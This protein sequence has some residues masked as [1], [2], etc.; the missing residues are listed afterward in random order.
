MFRRFFTKINGWIMGGYGKDNLFN[1]LIGLFGVVFLCFVALACLTDS[2]LLR[3]ILIF[4]PFLIL[5]FAVYRMLSKDTAKRANENRIFL[6]YKDKFFAFFK[7]L[8]NK[9][10]YRKTH[11]FKKCP[12]CK[13][14]LKLARIKGEHTVRCPACGQSFKFKI[15]TGKKKVEPRPV[16]K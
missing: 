4:A 15:R 1:F 14:N 5:I 6:Y 13:S 11:I 8:K 7:L 16:N 9:W 3:Y 12:N 2:L 10:K